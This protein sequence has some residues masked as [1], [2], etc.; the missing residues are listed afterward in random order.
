MTYAAVL[1]LR[2]TLI[3]RLPKRAECLEPLGLDVGRPARIE[4]R[5]LLEQRGKSAI[6][7]VPTE[8]RFVDLRA[9]R[10]GSPAATAGRGPRSARGSQ[11]IW[12]QRKLGIF[13]GEEKECHALLD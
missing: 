1:S 7:S 12:R 9:S 11:K 5:E 4:S 10:W 8:G 3:Q 2:G 6:R 13:R